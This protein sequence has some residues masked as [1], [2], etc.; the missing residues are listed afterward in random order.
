[1]ALTWAAST[2]SARCSLPRTLSKCW[3]CRLLPLWTPV[4]LVSPQLTQR[5]TADARFK[6]PPTRARHLLLLAR[7]CLSTDQY[8]K[9]RG[10]LWRRWGKALMSTPPRPKCCRPHFGKRPK[11]NLGSQDASEKLA[12]RQVLWHALNLRVQTGPTAA[13]RSVLCCWCVRNTKPPRGFGKGNL[14]P[15]GIRAFLAAHYCNPV[16]TALGCQDYDGL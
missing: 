7:N 3:P 11:W 16:C 2:V 5:L 15:A 6:L 4:S 9:V 12:K 8:R 13:A 1:M 10:A 14:C